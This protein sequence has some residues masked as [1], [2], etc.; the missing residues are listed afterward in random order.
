M[1]ILKKFPKNNRFTCFSLMSVWVKVPLGILGRVA[2]MAN[3]MVTR[4]TL[5]RV[6]A[7]TVYWGNCSR[8]F[9]N[10][11]NNTEMMIEFTEI[12]ICALLSAISLNRWWL[13]DVMRNM[14]SIPR[15]GRFLRFALSTPSSPGIRG[16]I[17]GFTEI[18]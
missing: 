9:N 2:R 1:L 5:N 16:F 18:G 13:P 17:F 10:T 11:L 12:I 4:L 7:G 3:T 14:V 8:F 6:M 15:S